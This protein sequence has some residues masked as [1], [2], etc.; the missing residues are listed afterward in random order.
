M[1]AATYLICDSFE[2]AELC[3]A[4]VC[5]SLRDSDGNKGA[6]WSGVY[7]DGTRFGIVWAPEVSAVF[8]SPEDNPAVVIAEAVADA[9]GIFDWQEVLPPEPA[10]TGI[11]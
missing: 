8:G 3:D 11:I 7:T 5:E 6:R 1:S 9:E 2:H 4:I 10:Q